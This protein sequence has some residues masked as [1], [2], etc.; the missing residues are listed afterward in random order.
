MKKV[1]I[2]SFLFFSCTTF[3]QEVIEYV[4]IY[5]DTSLYFIHQIDSLK[6]V[7]LSTGE[8]VEIEEHLRRAIN[9]FNRSQQRYADSVNP[10][11]KKR[12]YQ[13]RLIDVNNYFFKLIP[14]VNKEGQKEVRVNG[15]IK[16]YFI[17]GGTRKKPV[18]DDQWKRKFINGHEVIDGGSGFIYLHINLTLKTHN[19]LTMNGGG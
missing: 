18:F 8:L 11:N 15:D 10:K 13:A 1:V 5:K 4:Y 3:S 2:I 7:A 6:P 14:K 17:T 19:N 9:E 12:R 16:D